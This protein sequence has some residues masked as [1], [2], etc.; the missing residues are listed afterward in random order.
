LSRLYEQVHHYAAALEAIE[1][2]LAFDPLQEELQRTAMR[3]QFLGGD[4]AGVIRR[5]E[6]LRG[7]LDSELGVLPMVETRRLYDTIIS[8]TPDVPEPAG[9]LASARTERLRPDTVGPTILPFTGRA[10]QLRKLESSL[11]PGKLALVEGEPGIGKTRL[12]E[13]FIATFRP[14]TA[15]GA[16]GVQILRGRAY[17]MEQGLPYQPVV[18]ALRD[19]LGGRDQ[20]G[21]EFSPGL[22]PLWL[23]EVARLVPELGASYP[24]LPD[25]APLQDQSR[26][27]EGLR[28][29]FVHL[30][31]RGPLI[32]FLDDLQWADNATIAWLGYLTRRSAA[33]PLFL[34][35]AVRTPLDSRLTALIQALQYENR[36]ERLL[37]PPLND[38]DN[39]TLARHY[40]TAHSQHLSQWLA[41]YSEGNPYFMTELIRYAQD[42]GLLRA[43][44]TLDPER[45]DWMPILPPTIHNLIL[46]R[47][48]RISENARHVLEAIAVVGKEFSALIIG[49]LLESSEQK[50]IDALDELQ[51]A[52]LIL[53]RDG[54]FAF[55]HALTMEVI[56]QSMGQARVESLHRRTAEAMEVV[57]RDRTEV[58]AGL[59]AS[60]FAQG[61]AAWRA[62]PYAY[63]AGQLAA[64]L[65]AWTEAIAFYEQAL[66][67][68]TDNS[69]RSDVFLAM[70]MA[71]F[72]GGNFAAGTEAYRAALD[73][74]QK[75]GDVERMELAHISLNQSLLPQARY[76]EAIAIAEELRRDGPPELAACAEFNWGTGLAVESARPLE[77]ERHLCEAQRLVAAAPSGSYTPRISRA[78]IAY[79]LGGVLSQRGEIA[80]AVAQYREALRLSEV[81]RPLDL[82]R[83]IM[84]YNNLAHNLN[85]LADPEA[86]EYARLGIQAA[87]EK[88]SLSHLPYL[89]STSGEI[90]LT[91]NR[92]EE[93]QALFEEGLNIA[94]Q[95][96]LPERIAGLTANLGLVAARRGRRE[97]ALGHLARSLDSADAV[98]AQHLAVRIRMWLVPLSPPDEARR[99][100]VEARELAERGG[101]TQLLGEL[102]SLEVEF[103]TSMKGNR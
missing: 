19:L 61:K 43:D 46:S 5:Y 62:A 44:G 12:V 85:L 73:L 31:G 66:E 49:R 95:I 32:L 63:R 28:Q 40:S 4:R 30:A 80:A 55:D 15:A 88:G 36:L 70:G 96:P 6:K 94:E 22:A 78:Q 39:L 27:W 45:L 101:Y 79:Q 9:A 87:R 69:A 18:D 13:A 90:A 72:H 51:T 65:A 38:L 34:I 83:G 8:D 99:R 74:A 3:L 24:G 92:L 42:T 71:R 48:V 29:L 41:R 64:G 93:A 103:D 56:N 26:L 58:V 91:Q 77:A 54:L 21:L 50:V 25:V 102:A 47:L 52:G 10:A 37:L 89:L 67:G 11:S 76:Q 20:W 1:R 82:L 57:Y 100:L 53:P 59:L 75:V 86:I 17:E 68:E 7:Q 97:E 23:A 98:G 33:V 2:A 60:H 16:R 14:A 84:V 81:D 35:A